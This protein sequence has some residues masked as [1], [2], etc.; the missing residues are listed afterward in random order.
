MTFSEL[1]TQPGVREEVELRGRFGFLAYH[2]GSVER[3][4]SL[5]ARRAAEASSAT[6]YNIDQPPEKPLHLPSTR[7]RPEESPALASVI[8][9]C[10]VICTVHGYGREMTKQFLL[11]G[12]QNR[13]LAEAIGTE[14][15]NRLDEKYRVITNLE[16]IPRELRGVH[17]ENPVNLPAGKGVQLELP[18][19]V[20]WNFDARSWGDA[21]GLEPTDTIESIIEALAVAA[22]NWMSANE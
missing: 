9:H 12:G 20:R 14:L 2:G 1:L 15:S 22:S 21:D 7:F 4:T 19:G 18:P 10:E 13:E 6:Y 17:P 11:L 3:V 5:I 8:E 16:E